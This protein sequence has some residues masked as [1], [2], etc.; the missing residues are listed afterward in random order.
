MPTAW[1][2]KNLGKMG[3]VEFTTK[4]IGRELAT[5]LPTTA[6]QKISERIQIEPDK[7]LGEFMK[8][9][10]KELVDT[11][12]VVPFAAGMTGSMAHLQAKAGRLGE[13]TRKD[14]GTIIPDYSPPKFDQ[15]TVPMDLTQKE[16]L[17]AIAE[18]IDP[19]LLGVD[20]LLKAA[21]VV[22]KHEE[23]KKVPKL[24]EAEAEWAALSTA[25]K[26]PIDDIGELGASNKQIANAVNYPNP[27]NAIDRMDNTFL[28][29]P[30]GS[31]GLTPLQVIPKPATYVLGMETQ[32]RSLD[33]LNALQQSYEKWRVEFMP[34]SIIVLLNEQQF[35]DSALGWHYSLSGNR[36]MHVIVP[37]V[38][39]SPS[40]GLGAFNANTQ[41]S[42]F[43]N[44]THEFGHALVMAST[45]P[46]W[47]WCR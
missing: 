45:E 7:P 35:S 31:V 28:F 4:Y 16:S 32:D 29:G 38:L 15:P 11:A 22:K 3:A 36:R 8:Q 37:A 33:Y 20:E 24:P 42:A 19:E 14:T 40:K 39:R 5:E 6:V 2:V 44:A 13:A 30:E 27:N 12:L 23:L 46:R 17:E 21:E 10:G 41:A 25:P 9:L 1:L 47:S 43:F 26:S 34:N 18:A